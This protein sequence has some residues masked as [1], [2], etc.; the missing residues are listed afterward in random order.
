M[1]RRSFSPL[2][3]IERDGF[4]CHY[5]GELMNI[6]GNPNTPFSRSISQDRKRFTLEHIV[7]RSMGGTFGLY[8]LVG[9]CSEC[10]G[11]MGDSM[12]KCF[13]T[14]CQTARAKFE[15]KESLAS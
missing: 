11:K 8:N 9:A 12:Y 13:C 5:C 6:Y 15:M 2:R 4:A 1:G 3:I 7:P 10:N 14:F